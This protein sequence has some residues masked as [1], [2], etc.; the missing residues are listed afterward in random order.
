M[1][2]MSRR[3]GM[4]AVSAAIA[5]AVLGTGLHAAAADA[6]GVPLQTGLAAPLQDE[7]MLAHARA[8][9]VRFLRMTFSWDLIA[10]KQR[11]AHFEPANPD[12]PA[13]HWWRTDE[14]IMLAV[15]HGFT[16]YLSIG[17]PPPWGQSPEGAGQA[18]PDPVQLGL[19]THAF[20]ARYDGSRPGLPRL[21]YWE[22]WNEPNVS[23]F[24][25]PQLVKGHVA[26]VD[27]YRAMV[28]EVA[29]AVHSV[30]A[31]NIVIAG[32]L[33][34]NGIRRPSVTAIS[35]LEFTR[36]LLCLSAGAH[37]RRVCDKQVHADVWSVHPYTTG[38]PSTLPANPDNVWIY[39][40]KALTDL[41]R[42][43]QR[44]G[45]LLS[46]KPVQTWVTEF[47]WDSKP[48]DPKGVPATLERRWVAE[49]L[50]RAWRAGISMFSWYS[51]R[52]E[53]IAS[54]QQQSGLYFECAGG[55]SCDMPKPAAAAFRFPFVA[56]PASA[57]RLLVWGRTPLGQ[58]HRVRIQWLQGRRW[59]ALTTLMSDGD[60]IF[61]AQALLPSGASM[62][63]ALLRAV[64][65]SG[66]PSPAF[67]LHH[68]RDIIV[69][70]LG[71]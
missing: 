50:Y 54:S 12:D 69:A 32:S 15:S 6:Y 45:S 38:G 25:Q 3:S 29:A 71:S 56:Y 65:M 48:P 60:G 47:S 64:T 20:A 63:N 2:E 21:L 37:P 35:P 46:Q 9:G 51:L 17:D 66:A 53:P 23:F 68:P 49:A 31:D 7:A 57:R 61:T 70:P 43:G 11:P 10:P 30:H 55:P 41:V 42:A 34:P 39:N 24:M 40:L 58:P 13:Y 36:R 22:V 19:F 4:L 18:S 59:R 26:S 1:I 44:A 5:F 14:A 33:F 16:P 27:T 8:L 28:N 67:S 52:D 62:R